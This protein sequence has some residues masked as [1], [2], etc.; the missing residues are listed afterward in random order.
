[1]NQVQKLLDQ[2]KLRSGAQSDA[3]LARKLHVV[4][5][6]VSNWR[7]GITYPDAIA[8]ERL[9]ELAGRNLVEVVG[10]VGEARAR[11]TA[12]KWV[13]RRIAQAGAHAV[14]ILGATLLAPTPANA[15]AA[16]SEGLY[17]PSVYYVR[18]RR[19]GRGRKSGTW[20]ASRPSG[21]RK[22]AA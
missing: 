22:I 10:I 8:C 20:G 16:P 17:A 18:R 1:M 5:Q 13:W 6:A 7:T 21:S 14:L 2:A 15:A 11:S 3:D 12:E 9:A 19:Y 4:R